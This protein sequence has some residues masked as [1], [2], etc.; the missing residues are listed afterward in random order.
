M[1][2]FTRYLVKLLRT[3][4]INIIS[5]AFVIVFGSSAILF[6]IEPQ[7]FDTPL[8]ALWLV[9]TTVVTVGYGDLS[10]TTTLGKAYTMG[11]L[12][13]FGIGIIGLLIGKVMD[14]LYTY[15]Q[16]KE[17]GKLEY[18][19]EKHYIFIGSVSKIR[20]AIKEILDSDPKATFV[21]IGEQEKSP[22]P[23]GHVHFVQGYPSDEDVLLSANLFH[24]RSVSIFADE[25]I[26][27]AVF[28]DGKSL[29]IAS[30]VEKLSEEHNQN[31]HTIVEI[32]KESHISK[33]KHVN[34]DEFI[35]SNEA[36]SRL[37][38]QASLHQ[39]SSEL[40]RQLMSKKYGDNL[41]EITAKPDWKNY[42]DAFMALLN[43]GATL[44]ADR[45]QLDI[46]RKLDEP[47]PN[48]AKLFVVCD[49]ET[50]EQI[51]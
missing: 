36:I 13:V 4:F 7:T 26:S 12:Y 15:R 27:N 19:G 51:K 28:A 2:F 35:L 31:V 38:A 47:I 41:F 49:K 48:D 39:G 11:I 50:Y 10:P 42:R 44:V 33:F 34:I 5:F 43:Q 23:E 45:H 9:M 40:F 3:K 24:A 8:D 22:F 29:L 18:K 30:A 21:Y 16:L 37:V 25:D 32:M 17:E 14:S 46:N 6:Y 20:Q 1:H